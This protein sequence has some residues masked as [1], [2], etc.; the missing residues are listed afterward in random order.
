MT[1]SLL[2][3]LEYYE[4][5]SS[6]GD[7]RFQAV[8]APT[9]MSRLAPIAADEQQARQQ[10]RDFE[11]K[12]ASTARANCPNAVARIEGRSVEELAREARLDITERDSRF[13]GSEMTGK[14]VESVVVH[15]NEMR[16]VQMC[17]RCARRTESEGRRVDVRD[18]DAVAAENGDGDHSTA[19]RID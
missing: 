14:I 5:T 7:D 19:E 12:S 11:A 15:I 2:P 10:Q 1:D 8:V 4:Q 6:R 13:L 3:A 17:E 9:L 18:I 16:P